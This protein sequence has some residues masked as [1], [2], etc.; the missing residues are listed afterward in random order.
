MSMQARMSQSDQRLY[1]PSRD[2]AHNFDYLIK[3]VADRCVAGTWPE[4]R[5]IAAKHGL[6]DDALGRTVEALTKFVMGQNDIRGE[7]MANCLVRTGFYDQ[8]TIAKVVVMAYL[9]S[10]SLGTHW[11]GVHEATLNG[12]GPLLT[13]QGLRW[14]GRMSALLMR[15]PRWQRVLRGW[16]RR[17][18]T[19]WRALW[20]G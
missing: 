9:G 15:M 4:M 13:Y 7:S 5:A 8:P 11:A 14:Y 2:V 20:R 1:N 12:Q 16:H 18:R 19:S 6:T 3:E 10:I 17:L